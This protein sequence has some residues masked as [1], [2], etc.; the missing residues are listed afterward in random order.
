MPEEFRF[1]LFFLTLLYLSALRK[2]YV[3][4]NWKLWFK[5]ERNK[6]NNP[7]TLKSNFM[8]WY[9]HKCGNIGKSNDVF[10]LH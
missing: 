3:L 4:E 10:Y 8:F 5:N 1:I 2:Y 6:S 9:T 7:L